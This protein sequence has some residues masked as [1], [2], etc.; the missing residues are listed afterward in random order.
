MHRIMN[1]R[2]SYRR[3]LAASALF[4]MCCLLLTACGKNKEDDLSADATPRVPQA[5]EI[6]ITGSNFYDY[7]DFKEYPNYVTDED[8]NINACNLSYG[9][10]LHE[11]LIAANDPKHKDTL[12]VSFQ[13]EGI[14]QYGEFDVNYMTLQ[15]SG[16]PLSEQ[17]ENI[18]ETLTFWPQGNRTISYP[19]GTLSSSYIIRLYNFT[20]TSVSGSIWL[21]R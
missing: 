1:Q 8:G 2:F 21:L 12:R 7:F 18:A 13:A 16:T 9:F 3:L 20:V 4:L 6:K 17:R 14:S 11:G 10:S 15:Y 19:Y 5:E